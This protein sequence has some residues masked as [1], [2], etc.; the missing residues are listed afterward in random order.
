VFFHPEKRMRV[1]AEEIFKLPGSI[2]PFWH[3]DTLIVDAGCI[4]L[5]AFSAESGWA[6]LKQMEEST[7][8]CRC[9]CLKLSYSPLFARH[10]SL[11]DYVFDYCNLSMIFYHP[12]SFADYR[13]PNTV[14]T[15]P[16]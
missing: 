3:D 13:Q 6:L 11:S 8:D 1:K 2:L 12:I 10:S 16:I 15:D 4:N 9:T 14:A 7:L 5:A